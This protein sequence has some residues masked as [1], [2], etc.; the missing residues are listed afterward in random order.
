MNKKF[1]TFLIMGVAGS[2]KT[3]IAEKLCK[4]MNAFLIEGDDYHSKNNVKKMSSGIPLND[5]DR[6][7]WLIKIREEIKTT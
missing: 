3:T 4:K 2:G 1:V 5:E 7:D 6:H